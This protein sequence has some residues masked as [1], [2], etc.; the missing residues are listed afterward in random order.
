[1]EF[2]L[3]LI[4][5]L[6]GGSPEEAN[7]NIMETVDTE[8]IIIKNKEISA[9]TEEETEEEINIFNLVQFH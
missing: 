8:E 6:F 7:A 1:M 3:Q 9:I 5:E 2:L 4:A